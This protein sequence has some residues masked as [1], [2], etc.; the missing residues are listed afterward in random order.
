MLLSLFSL[1]LSFPFPFFL[2]YFLYHNSFVSLVCLSSLFFSL[3]VHYLCSFIQ[4]H[5]SNNSISPFVLRCSYEHSL[6]F[7]PLSR[8]SHSSDGSTPFFHCIDNPVLRM[9]LISSMIQILWLLLYL[10]Y[11]FMTERRV[12]FFP[13]ARF[14]SSC[15][16][17]QGITRPTL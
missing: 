5:V 12:V 10:F 15:S 1:F 2:L 17:L 4:H 14:T 7:T 11:R 16:V 8:G 9:I 6:L 3:Q 13:F